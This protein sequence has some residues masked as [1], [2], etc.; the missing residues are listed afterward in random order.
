MDLAATAKLLRAQSIQAEQKQ[1]VITLLQAQLNTYIYFM[2]ETSISLWSNIRKKTWTDGGSVKLPYQTKR[3]PNRTIIGAIGGFNDQ[4]F[5][6]QYLICERTCKEDV[7]A[8]VRQL[9]ANR[10][11]KNIEFMLV[12]DNHAA[13]HSRYVTEYLA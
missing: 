12:A 4:Q 2:D 13:H 11:N 10:P 6:F 5:D 3:G 8:F 9:I 7:L 1:F